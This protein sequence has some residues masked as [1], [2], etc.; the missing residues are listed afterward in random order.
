M[1]KKLIAFAGILSMFAIELARNRVGRSG[2]D[3][4]REGMGFFIT[5]DQWR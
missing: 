4:R 5:V 1:R 3:G 2:W